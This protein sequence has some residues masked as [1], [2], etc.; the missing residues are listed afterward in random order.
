MTLLLCGSL[1]PAPFC[2][3][4][5]IVSQFAGET[6]SENV[7]LYVLFKAGNDFCP[8]PEL[9]VITFRCYCYFSQLSV[10]VLSLFYIHASTDKIFP[11]LASLPHS[12]LRIITRV[13]RENMT[14]HPS[15]VLSF[16]CHRLLPFWSI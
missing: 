9:K 14:K 13:R 15:A 11:C 5:G 2:L 3:V 4:Q 1:R 8:F 16:L 7:T 6:C 10:K 12:D